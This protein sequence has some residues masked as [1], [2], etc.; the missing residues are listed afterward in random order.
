MPASRVMPRR[1]RVERTV[2][3]RLA[4][5]LTLRIGAPAPC[6]LVGSTRSMKQWPLAFTLSDRISPVI[7]TSSGKVLRTARST[8]AYRSVMDSASGE[9][10]SAISCWTRDS[11][12]T[13]SGYDPGETRRIIRR[14][15]GSRPARRAGGAAVWARPVGLLGSQTYSS[16]EGTS[17]GEAT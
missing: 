8:R 2:R 17:A 3:Q 10:A 9:A 7:H 14:R 12:D 13:V 1:S 11:R 15:Q 16:E 5:H 6:E 4:Q